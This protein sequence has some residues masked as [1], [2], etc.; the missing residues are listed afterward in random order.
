MR[1]YP[2]EVKGKVF[3]FSRSGEVYGPTQKQY[4]PDEIEAAR[5]IAMEE[6]TQRRKEAA[7]RASETRRRRK[8]AEYYS[9]A[10]Q[11]IRGI[12]F[13]PRDRCRICKKA[14]TDQQSRL[15]GIGPE[16]W[17][18]VVTIKTELQAKAAAATA[19]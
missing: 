19:A 6:I 18:R 14:L 15:R 10:D 17:E 1:Y 8:E 7:A 12:T 13:G 9:V 2:T 5:K 16:C 4:T 3:Y 11:L